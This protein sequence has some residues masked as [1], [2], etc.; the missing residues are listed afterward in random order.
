N[1]IHG[2]DFDKDG[3]T[4]YIV[5]NIGQNNYYNITEQYPLRVY[6]KDIDNNGSIDPVLSCY[7][8]SESGEMV[9]Y[10]VHF[11]DELY[12]QSPLFRNQFSRYRQYGL[13]DMKVLLEPH[14][15]TDMQVFTANYP[16]TSYVENNGNGTFTMHP[17]P[18][19]AQISPVNGI[20]TADVNGDGNLDILV[21]GNDYGNEVFSG[22][23]DAGEGLVLLGDGKG[24]FSELPSRKSGFA[25]RGDAKALA[26][27]KGVDGGLVIATQNL[28]SLRIFANVAPATSTTVFQPLPG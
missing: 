10:P 15:V 8:K 2:A 14:N 3:D 28:D 18:K 7:F 1:S 6:A 24:A 26:K 5:G 4:D 22:R 23:F 27:L 19:R 9:E 21:I 17:L 20:V 25:V 11:W 13:A 16:Y 12:G